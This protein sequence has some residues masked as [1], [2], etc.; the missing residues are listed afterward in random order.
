MTKIFSI[1]SSVAVG[2]LAMTATAQA[3]ELA[4]SADATDERKADIIVN[5]LRVDEGQ[6]R[7]TGNG[8]SGAKTLLDTPYSITVVDREDIS[9]RQATSIGQIFVNDPAVFSYSPAG[10]TDWWGTQIRGLG[11]RNYY[12]D[13]VPLMLYWGG[14][15]PL[16]SVETVEALKGLSGFMYGFGAPG[17]TISYRTKRPTAERLL[18]TELGWRATGDVFAHVDAGGPLT[19]DGRLGYRINVAGEKGRLYNEAKNNRWLASAALEY[20]LTPDIKWYGTAAYEESK[21]EAEPFQVYWYAYED[22]K[23]PKPTTDYDK[24]NIDNSFYRVH[25]LSAATGLDWGFADGWNARLTY[26]YASKKHW[27]NKMFATVLNQAGDYTGNAYNFAWRDRSHFARAMVQGEVGT[28]PIR[29][30]IVAGASIIATESYRSNEFYWSEDFTGNLYQDQPFRVTRAFDWS[31]DPVPDKQRQYALF[32]SDTIH[33]GDHVQAVVGGRQTWYRLLALPGDPDSGYRTSTLSPTFALIAKPAP[34]ASLYGSYVESLEPGSQ[35]G[36]EYANAGEMLKATV[37]KQFEVGAKV[38]HGGVSFT[39]A[40]FRIERVNTAERWKAGVSQPYLRQDGQTLYKGVELIGSWR[41]AKQLK[42]GAGVIRL[43]PELRKLSPMVDED[44]TIL[45]SSLVGNIPA[46]AAK[47][48]VT[49]NVEYAVSGVPG[50]SLHANARY[51]GKAPT[52]D[53]NILY[54]PSRTIANA[55]FQ[56]ET[57]IGGQK[58]AFT[59]NVNNLFNKK[60]WG[61]GNIGEGMNGALSVRIYW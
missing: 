20:A 22:A 37:S 58:V 34:W 23:L 57:L 26:G 21:L 12:I 7:V 35:V 56:Y 52:G 29:H 6:N 5:G 13:D 45:P 9:M 60:Y 43:D 49:G 32:L 38:E 18:T 46:E 33:I 14:T 4:D 25:T 30:A 50:L 41:M 16:E 54:I 48:Q 15:Y 27:S 47:W 40:A 51:F 36:G 61:L 44:G 28:G 8:A 39:A 53:E 1:C 55:G 19:Q 17:G 11:V 24:L 10:T 42:L 31:M 2:L 59:G 3:S